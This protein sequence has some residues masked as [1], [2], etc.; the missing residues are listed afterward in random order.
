[1]QL[2]FLLS[3]PSK[4]VFPCCVE[5]LGTDGSGSVLLQTTKDSSF[6]ESLSQPV[7]EFLLGGKTEAF[8]ERV[9]GF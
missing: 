1:M 2:D 9:R 5:A 7:S 4:L 6:L 3:V 8:A